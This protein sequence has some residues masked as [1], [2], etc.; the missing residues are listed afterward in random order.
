MAK[1]HL[2]PIK[3]MLNLGANLALELLDFIYQ[4]TFFC[5]TFT[6]LAALPVTHGNHPVYLL[7][8]VLFSFLN[9]L[10]P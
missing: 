3:R 10:I 7:A 4:S 2:D 5:T 8:L 6:Q 9:A 1:V